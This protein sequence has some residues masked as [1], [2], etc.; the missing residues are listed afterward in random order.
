MKAHARGPR[1]LSSQFV[2]IAAAI[3]AAYV[4]LQLLANGLLL[5]RYYTFRT[6][7][8]LLGAYELVQQMDGVDL[9][10]MAA[11]EQQD[12]TVAL[13]EAGTG[14]VLYSSRSEDAVRA[15]LLAQVLAEVREGLLA[16]HEDVFVAKRDSSSITASGT[17]LTIDPAMI[18]GARVGLTLVELSIQLE[19]IQESTAI[20]QQFTAVVGILMLL[21]MSIVLP[22][23]ARLIT[24]PVE[25]MTEAAQC[26][27]Q[28]DFS[29]R[30]DDSFQHEIGSLAHSINSMSDQLQRYTDELQTAN[31]RLKE[32]LEVIRRAQQARRSL[33]SNISHDIK[34]PI[35]LIS[36]Y[37]AGLASGMADTPE[38]MREYCDVIIDESDRML[39]MIDRMLQLSRIESGAV[40]LT[41]E[42]FSLSEL[43]DDLLEKFHV[44]IE[45][46]GIA[47]TRAYEPGACV[48]SD[49]V[50]VEQVLTNY[51][52]NAVEHMGAGRE[53]RITVRR[54]EHDRLRV[55]VFNSAA[56][57][58]DDERDE[59]WDS[60]YRGEKSR[61]RAG[62]QSGLGLAIVRGNM[63]LLGERYGVENVPG[64]V[65]F[66]LELPE[67][68]TEN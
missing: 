27:A 4:F 7:Q 16:A 44:E 31:D 14:R 1:R 36:G 22:R 33:V 6:R 23:A 66:Y 41:M 13:F 39:Q 37:A 45:R 65:E 53:M 68:K 24:R 49:Y 63:Q 19:T 12:I 10:T 60:F 29:R 43:L 26:I 55:S 61:K 11:I 64:G 17:K 59:L 28:R 46:A 48:V 21:V 56:P 62:S 52:Q 67:E 54:A 3:I 18:L 2:F 20:A 40:A 51:I 50:C 5:E 35:A 42:G 32:D 34:T 8:K 15:R 9:A 57:F 25:Q 47:L 38:K 58:S 30:C